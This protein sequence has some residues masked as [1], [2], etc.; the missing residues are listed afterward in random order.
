MTD[1]EKDA[2]AS[3]CYLLQQLLTSDEHKH[4]VDTSTLDGFE[5][6]EHLDEVFDYYWF[7]SAQLEPEETEDW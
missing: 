7:R 5:N 3:V 4:L 6:K 2:L 1:R